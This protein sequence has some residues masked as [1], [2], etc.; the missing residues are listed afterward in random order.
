MIKLEKWF[1]DDMIT[2][3]RREIVQKVIKLNGGNNDLTYLRYGKEHPIDINDLLTL[4]WRE[5]KSKY[6]DGLKLY[7]YLCGLEQ[8]KKLRSRCQKNG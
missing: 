4:S 6:H 3:Y 8:Y 5:L 7:I 1:P 2:E